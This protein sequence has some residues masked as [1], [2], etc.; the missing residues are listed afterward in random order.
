MTIAALLADIA[1]GGFILSVI[2]LI[3]WD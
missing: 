3:L 2:T 1:L